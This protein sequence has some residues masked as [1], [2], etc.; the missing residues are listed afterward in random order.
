MAT[1]DYPTLPP[2]LTPGGSSTTTSTTKSSPMGEH[3][4][5]PGSSGKSNITFTIN[6]DGQLVGTG[7]DNTNVYAYLNELGGAI[8]YGDAE[9]GLINYYNSTGKMPMLLR[10]LSILAGKQVQLGDVIWRGFINSAITQLSAY[11][12]QQTRYDG[13][14]KSKTLLGWIDYLT[15]SGKGTG[16]GAP[17]QEVIQTERNTAWDIFKNTSLQLTNKVPSKKDFEDFYSKLLSKEKK[18]ISKVSVS[19]NTRY[20]TRAEFNVANF[21]LK[22]L[23]DRVDFNNKDLNGTAKTYLNKVEQLMRDNGVDNSLHT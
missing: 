10:K 19:G 21:T 7:P 20:N 9:D 2:N 8:S 4:Y 23:V 3:T 5:N 17:T 18:Y 6:S 13:T 16:G 11:N 14:G 22:Y 15:K 12:Y 1:F